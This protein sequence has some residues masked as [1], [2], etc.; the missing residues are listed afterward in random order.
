MHSVV[1]TRKEKKEIH[2]NL[3]DNVNDAL[4]STDKK[5]KNEIR[6][7]LDDNV[8]D[9]LRST[10]K[11]RQK[12]SR[13]KNDVEKSEAFNYVQGMSMVDPT[14]LHTQAYKIIQKVY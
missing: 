4:R 11:E 13:Q 2:K 14:I 5:R 6:K 9:A 3:D 1:L 8:K 10:D 12:D 7:N